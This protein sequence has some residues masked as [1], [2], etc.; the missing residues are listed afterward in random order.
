[1]PHERTLMFNQY[2]RTNMRKF[3]LKVVKDGVAERTTT[4]VRGFVKAEKKAKE[5]YQELIDKGFYND[6]T[7]VCVSDNLSDVVYQDTDVYILK[8]DAD[9]EITWFRN[10][11][12]TYCLSHCRLIN[13]VEEQEM[14]EWRKEK[15]IHIWDLSDDE[16]KKLYNE[17]AIGSIYTCDYENSFNIDNLEVSNYCDEYEQYLEDFSLE[18]TPQTFVDFME[19]YY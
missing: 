10:I 9:G 11:Y 8:K 14:A 1:M 19:E 7:Y 13:E 6:D 5:L 15:D 18:D 4:E 17:I 3:Y 2:N 16:L 12:G